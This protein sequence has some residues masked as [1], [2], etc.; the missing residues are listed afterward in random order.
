MAYISQELL[1]DRLNRNYEAFQYSLRGV[2]RPNLFKMAGRISA[3]TEAFEYLTKGHEWDDE[4]EIAY[5]LKFR[6][7]LTIIADLWED[8]RSDMA[9]DLSGTI[10]DALNNSDDRILADYPRAKDWESLYDETV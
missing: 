9:C 4:D 1:I 6:D 5:F 7:P 3:V 10:W 8:Y 2:S